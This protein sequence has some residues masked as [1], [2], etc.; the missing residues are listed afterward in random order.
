M[1]SKSHIQRKDLSGN[2]GMVLRASGNG[3]PKGRGKR[4]LRAQSDVLQ[5]TIP[6]CFPWASKNS[7]LLKSLPSFMLLHPSHERLPGSKSCP[8]H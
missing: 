6:A 1:K 5:L 8:S 3:M 7:G 4:V 2:S